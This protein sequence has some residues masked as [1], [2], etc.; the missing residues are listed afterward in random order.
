MSGV[1]YIPDDE[2][3][4]PDHELDAHTDGVA[5]SHVV[6]IQLRICALLLAAL[7]TLSVL[8]HLAWRAYGAAITHS[9]R[10]CHGALPCYAARASARR[11]LPNSHHATK[12]TRPASRPLTECLLPPIAVETPESRSISSKVLKKHR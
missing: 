9:R 5:T 7:F 2:E 11:T 4:V 10:G 3:D 6:Q 1:T 8:L 12:V